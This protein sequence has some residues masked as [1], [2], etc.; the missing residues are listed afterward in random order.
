[1][2][3]TSCGF[4]LLWAKQR[5][6]NMNINLSIWSHQIQNTF[7]I[8]Y[9]T[10]YSDRPVSQCSQVKLITFYFF[11]FLF[12]NAINNIIFQRKLHCYFSFY[13]PGVGAVIR[14]KPADCCRQRLP[15]SSA[16]ERLE[17]WARRKCALTFSIDSWFRLVPCF[18]HCIVLFLL[19]YWFLF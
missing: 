9:G 7:L 3:V 10:Q 1:M 6:K 4:V 2:I 15:D 12:S 16:A 5:Q 18:N 14:G 13:S 17:R 8:L 11:F 19:F